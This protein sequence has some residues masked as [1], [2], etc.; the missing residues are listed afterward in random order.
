MDQNYVL[1][2]LKTL[3]LF[4]P[5]PSFLKKLVNML[6]YLTSNS[7]NPKIS[8]EVVHIKFSNAF[9]ITKFSYP[10]LSTHPIWSFLQCYSL[11]LLETLS[12]FDFHDPTLFLL[13]PLIIAK[14]SQWG[15]SFTLF[16]LY[17][18]C[19]DLNSSYSFLFYTKLIADAFLWN[20]LF[21]ECQSW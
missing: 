6:F 11:A 2:C 4:L 3:F 12:P 19:P 14:I 18:P 7:E 10:L 17:Q 15:F 21:D 5:L 16:F 1:H 9:L 8:L 20:F 13:P